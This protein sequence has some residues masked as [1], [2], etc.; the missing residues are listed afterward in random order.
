MATLPWRSPALAALRA[1][2]AAGTSCARATGCQDGRQPAAWRQTKAGSAVTALCRA[3][4]VWLRAC[5]S[6]RCR[7]G[8]RKYSN[9]SR[10]AHMPAA[11]SWSV[12]KASEPCRLAQPV[13]CRALREA[14]LPACV[15][16]AAG[17]ALKASAARLAPSPAQGAA[18]ALPDGR[19]RRGRC[20]GL[21]SGRCGLVNV[22]WPA[23]LPACVSCAAGGATP[24]L[25]RSVGCA[26]ISCQLGRAF[27]QLRARPEACPGLCVQPQR[28]SLSLPCV[29]WLE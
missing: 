19:C 18:V 14:A 24:G 23:G 29:L 20:C 6:C 21:R 9:S 1:A 16:G 28:G 15:P 17:R 2:A 7:R 5:R 8:A 12:H 27:S 22:R 11:G 13:L 10:T 3:L 26:C 4:V 25:G